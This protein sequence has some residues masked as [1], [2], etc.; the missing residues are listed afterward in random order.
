MKKIYSLIAIFAA[1]SAANAQATLPVYE[2]FDYPTGAY[3][4]QQTGYTGFN[5][6]DSIAIVS[7]SLQY[8][9]FPTS[10]GN[11]IN[12]SGAGMETR[13]DIESVNSDTIY[14]SFLITINDISGVTDSNGGYFAGFGASNTLLGNSLWAKQVNDTIFKFGA[15]VRTS[16][17]GVTWTNDDYNTGETYFVVGAYT[18]VN[19]NQNDIARLWINPELGLSTPPQATITDQWSASNDLNSIVHFFLRRDSATKTPDVDIDELR[20]GSSWADVTPKIPASLKKNEIQGLNVYPNPAKDFV[21]VHSESGLEKQVQI[22]DMTGKKVLNTNTNSQIDISNL[23]KGI[24]VMR[25]KENGKEA[26]KKLII[27]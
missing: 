5:T 1:M 25:I 17:T 13:Y 12:F 19:G 20:I 14:Y 22:F 10:I 6:G 21:Y 4:H 3:L 23:K 8:P 16:A 7:G 11:K 27:K 24:Y 18:F 15:E 26:T 2:P 9:D